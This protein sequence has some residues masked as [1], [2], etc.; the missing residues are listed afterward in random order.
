MNREL[1][2]TDGVRGLAGQYPLDSEGAKRIGMAVGVHFGQPG[3]QVVIGC[4]T[5][6]SSAQIVADLTAGLNAVGINVVSAGVLPT[7]G[8]S[9]LT[10]EHDEFVAGVMVTAS[11]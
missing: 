11:H 4:D 7:P 6:E 9:Y 8:I 10:R 5:R 3:Q 1:F 2:G